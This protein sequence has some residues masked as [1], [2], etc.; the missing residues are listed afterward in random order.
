[1]QIILNGEP[2]NL[3]DEQPEQACVTD[4]IEQLGLTGQ[5]LAI[6]VNGNIV[7]RS[8]HTERQ[9]CAGDRVEVVRAIGG[10]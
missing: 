1:M 6:E 5:R 3:P 10:G 9:L 7:P 8:Q 4:L 2:H